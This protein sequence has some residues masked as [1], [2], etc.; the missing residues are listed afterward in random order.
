V[1]TISVFSVKVERSIHEGFGWSHLGQQENRYVLKIQKA[2]Q[3]GRCAVLFVFLI[4]Q[5]KNV[6]LVQFLAT[7]GECLDEAGNLAFKNVTEKAFFVE[8]LPFT[9]GDVAIDVLVS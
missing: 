6:V 4:K 7:F 8:E 3:V 2:G 5:L 9:E 1:E